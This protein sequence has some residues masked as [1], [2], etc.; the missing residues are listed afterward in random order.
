RRRLD[1]EDREHERD[2]RERLLATRELID[3]RVLLARRLR[4]DLDAG[5]E[6][7]DAF[8]TRQRERRLTAAEQ[9]REHFLERGIDRVERV[10]EQLAAGLVD[11]V[12]RA[13]ERIDRALEIDL[14]RRQELEPRGDLGELL[15]RGQVDVRAHA[16]DEV[17]ELGEPGFLDLG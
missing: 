7:V 9:P 4:H 17:L 15:D 14:L 13:L 5:L 11:L 3:R 2:S 16:I 1:Q 6:Q 8:A 10:L 12:D